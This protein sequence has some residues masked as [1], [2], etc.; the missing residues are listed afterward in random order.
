VEDCY[1]PKKTTRAVNF[2]VR[3]LSLP[4]SHTGQ[5]W[6]V[7][8][9]RWAA[10]AAPRSAEQPVLAGVSKRTARQAPDPNWLE[11][12][13]RGNGVEANPVFTA[14]AGRGWEEAAFG[15]GDAAACCKSAAVR[16]T[17]LIG[18][19]EATNPCAEVGSDAGTAFVC[20]GFS[21]ASGLGQP[22]CL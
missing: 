2:K 15:L 22:A 12:L 14:A 11:M 20:L 5:R 8:W 10:G 9:E 6:G 19:M 3:K 16:L 13:R 17:L 21:P 4:L 7:C 1:F 18:T